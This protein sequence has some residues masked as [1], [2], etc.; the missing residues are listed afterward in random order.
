MT[1][2]IIPARL[3]SQRLPQKALREVAGVPLIA[4]VS[5]N[6]SLCPLLDRVIVATDDESIAQAARKA[7]VEAMMTRDD[8]PSGTDRIAEIAA[9]LDDE[10]IVNIQGDEPEVPMDTLAAAIEMLQQDQ[11]LDMATAAA[12][13]TDLDEFLSPHR[14]KV[15]LEKNRDAL[16]FSRSPIP[17]PRSDHPTDKLVL[18]AGLALGHI[19][20][21]VYRRA[22]L[23]RLVAMPPSPLERS[24]RLEQLRALEN[25][26]RIGVAV[27]E[28]SPA[29]ID[30]EEDLEAFRRRVEDS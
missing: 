18:P 10:I 4:H 3:G 6:A 21:Y 2:G 22:A 24:E 8:H 20:L 5:R 1:T 16:Y 30:T 25:G 15:V 23:M 12:P 13:L 19:G 7:G 27:V 14:V 17:Y 11:G 9:Q 26:M 29:G 28:Q